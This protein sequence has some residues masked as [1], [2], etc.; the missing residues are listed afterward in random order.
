MRE[1]GSTQQKDRPRRRDPLDP[2]RTVSRSS[3]PWAK[4]EAN[5][6]GRFI[7]THSLKK[8]L[9][10]VSLRPYLDSID[11]FGDFDMLFGATLLYLRILDIPVHYCDRG[12]ERPTSSGGGTAHGAILFRMLWLAARKIKFI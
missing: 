10:A 8:L 3:S 4:R 9:A 5:R 1:R 12:M 6:S 7:A 11:P 2:A